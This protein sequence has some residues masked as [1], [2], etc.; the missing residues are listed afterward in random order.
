M[1]CRRDSETESAGQAQDSDGAFSLYKGSLSDTGGNVT[2]I[3]LVGAGGEAMD[4]ELSTSISKVHREDG[5]DMS[6]L[7]PALFLDNKSFYAMPS[8]T[9]SELNTF[10]HFN[11]KDLTPDLIRK[12]YL[13]SR[14]TSEMKFYA[15]DGLSGNLCELVTLDLTSH[16]G[17]L[18]F[19]KNFH[20]LLFCG[21]SMSGN[22]SL[23]IRQ[24][25]E[26]LSQP[27]L[28]TAVT[29]AVQKGQTRKA[30]V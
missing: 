6:A 8:F 11:E 16:P 4:T 12:E 21:I 10:Q 19:Q 30:M 17:T 9:K 15:A 13:Y 3:E 1:S 7:R 22:Q 2:D 28:S 5:L 29:V 27:L 24:L 14:A 23:W 26:S 25:G 20:Q 18:I